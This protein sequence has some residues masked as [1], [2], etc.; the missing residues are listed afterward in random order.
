MFSY[1]K[2]SI[3]EK[4]TRVVSHRRKAFIVLMTAGDV[5]MEDMKKRITGGRKT[6]HT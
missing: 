1:G 4:K 6:W 3:L 2:S 5:H